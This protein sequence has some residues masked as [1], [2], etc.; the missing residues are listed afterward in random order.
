MRFGKRSSAATSATLREA[1]RPNA[2]HAAFR[3]LVLPH[4][5][6][7]YNL[8]RYLTRDPDL[9][10]DVVQDAFIR[11][12]NALSQFRGGSARAWLLTI[13]RNCCHS[14]MSARRREADRLVFE[15]GWS[16]ADFDRVQ[17]H[18][19]DQELPEELLGREQESNRLRE[20]IESLPEPFR[21]ALVLRDVDDLSYKEIAEVTG[22][23][24][25]TVMSRLSRARSMA[26][27]IL[28]P[29]VQ[30]GVFRLKA[31]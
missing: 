31:R 23:A 21:E 20:M 29:D 26:A 4:L 1:V 28:R 22:V 10:E 2:D 25:G 13:V 12:L 11:A 9:S 3:A 24:I 18:A 30:S 27:E 15:N 5:D 6:S 17:N 14:A 8:A 7:A 16:S 19:D